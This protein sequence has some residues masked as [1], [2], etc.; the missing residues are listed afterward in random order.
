MT[1]KRYNHAVSTIE[2]SA[3]TV[4]DDLCYFTTPTTTTTTTPTTTT[5]TNP[6]KPVNK[7]EKNTN[8]IHYICSVLA[9]VIII[10]IAIPIYM[11]KF[12]GSKPLKNE[13][14][15]DEGNFYFKDI[16]EIYG[17]R[18]TYYDKKNVI[19]DTNDYY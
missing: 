16:N 8:K 10:I 9:L 17:E 18:E 15:G 1:K 14:H 13:L 4:E 7:F 6:E 2:Q 3:I 11:C 5:T 12:K 19:T